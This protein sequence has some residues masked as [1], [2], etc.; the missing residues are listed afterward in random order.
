MLLLYTIRPIKFF[1]HGFGQKL[2]FMLFGQIDK[3]YVS[4]KIR[5]SIYFFFYKGKGKGGS[6]QLLTLQFDRCLTVRNSPHTTSQK[7]E[8]QPY[9]KSSAP[10]RK[11][12]QKSGRNL[13]STRTTGVQVSRENRR[14]FYFFKPEAILFFSDYDKPPVL[15][16][17]G[18]QFSFPR[19]NTTKKKYAVHE[20]LTKNLLHS[21]V[22]RN[23]RC[24]LDFIVNKKYLTPFDFSLKT[25]TR[26]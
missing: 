16:F 6:L 26:N 23:P 25:P 20:L 18:Y 5:F 7:T 8:H 14:I 4:A 1:F 21:A 10:I 11:N 22:F 3:L 24:F 12:P 2:L 15:V 19:V 17:A 13:K 9:S